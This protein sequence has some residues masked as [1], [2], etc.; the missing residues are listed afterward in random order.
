MS[1]YKEEVCHKIKQ[2][3]TLGLNIYMLLNKFK[4]DSRLNPEIPEEVIEKVCDRY[5]QTR[6]YIRKDYPYFLKVLYMESS[7]Y[8][9]RQNAKKA[10]QSVNTQLL[11]DI[12]SSIK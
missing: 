6:G 8:F 1:K 5:L 11:K 9:S 2:V 12:F 4:K 10:D 7:A 3:Y